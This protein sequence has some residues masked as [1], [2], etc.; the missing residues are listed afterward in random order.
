MNLLFSIVFE[1]EVLDLIV[2]ATICRSLEPEDGQGFLTG[3]VFGNISRND[4]L[5]LYYFVQ[6]AT[7]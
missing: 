2:P 6:S 4:K 7:G 5:A 3:L 1:D